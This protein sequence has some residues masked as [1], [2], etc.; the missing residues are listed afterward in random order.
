VG[1]DVIEAHGTVPTATL[2]VG[3]ATDDDTGQLLKRPDGPQMGQSAV[4]P[5]EVFTHIL[6]EQDCTGKVG[7]PRRAD[8][9]LQ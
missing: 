5:V 3:K 8:Q 9:T 6:Q 2:Q 7:E 4:D 1:E